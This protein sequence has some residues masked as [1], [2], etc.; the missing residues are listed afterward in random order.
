MFH[1]SRLG[2]YIMI[3]I[4]IQTFDVEAQVILVLFLFH[5]IPCSLKQLLSSARRTSVL[6]DDL[7]SRDSS[8]LFR[9]ARRSYFHLLVARKSFSIY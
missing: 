1:S 8:A 5:S 9:A 4:K 7:G 2:G 3:L 6:A